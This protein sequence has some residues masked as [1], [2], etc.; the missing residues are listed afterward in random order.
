M[1]PAVILLGITESQ[2][3]T[4]RTIVIAVMASLLTASVEVGTIEK[5]RLDKQARREFI[6]RAQVR[7]PVSVASANMRTGPESPSIPFPPNALVPCDYV[8]EE[9]SGSSPKFACRL[10][11]GE[12]VKVRYGGANGEVVGSVLGSRLLWALGYGADRV[13]P[14][15]VRC[16]G[17]ST[18]PWTDHGQAD[19]EQIFDPATI[20]FDPEGD[21]ITSDISDSGWGWTELDLVE[22]EEGGAP[23]AHRDGLVLLAVLLQHTDSKPKQQR[24][25]CLPGGLVNRECTRPFL[26]V[27]DVGLTFGR[28][29]ATNTASTASVNFE[30][31]STTPVWRDASACVGNLRKSL[32]GSL[33]H[34]RI[35]EAG[36]ALLSGLLEQLEDRQLHDLFEVAR[37]QRRSRNPADAR[38]TVSASVDEW[39][40]A[41]KEKREEIAR[42]RC[43]N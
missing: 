16:R 28:A 8:E 19:G 1:P 24:L 20:E 7:A 17:C 21:E 42:A 5:L 36:R 29:N 11:N 39:V 41:F 15:R 30:A 2:L 32:S 33:E 40:D 23:L 34:P 9:M 22:E 27:H 14:V 38:V 43:G 25:W 13:F 10:D 3:M 31:W 35:R 12:T 18:D 4:P 26:F 37:V 6:R